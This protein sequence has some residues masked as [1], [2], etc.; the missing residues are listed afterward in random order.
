MADVESW[1]T[2]ACHTTGTA[3]IDFCAAHFKVFSAQT[4]FHRYVEEVMLDSFRFDGKGHVIVSEARCKDPRLSSLR[5]R[6]PFHNLSVCNDRKGPLD[7]TNEFDGSQQ[8]GVVLAREL[9]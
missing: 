4:S 1:T 3:Q 8:S 9:I 7:F 6:N 2:H 5:M